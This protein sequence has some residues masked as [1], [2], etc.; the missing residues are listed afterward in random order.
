[1][2]NVK[3]SKLD[4]NMALLTFKWMVEMNIKIFLLKEDEQFNLN[5]N[6]AFK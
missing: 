1:M 4:G 3:L 2:I 5:N 6:N